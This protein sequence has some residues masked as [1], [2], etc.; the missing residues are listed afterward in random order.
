LREVVERK[1][2]VSR[3]FGRDPINERLKLVDSWCRDKPGSKVYQ[4]M[5]MKR[6]T[7]DGVEATRAEM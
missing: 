2:A 5:W 4:R 7:R 1:V 6:E 3:G